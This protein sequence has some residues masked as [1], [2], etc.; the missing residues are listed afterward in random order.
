MIEDANGKLIHF[1]LLGY[2]DYTNYKD[3]RIR[4]RYLQSVSK[5]IGNWKTNNI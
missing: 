3:D 5:I 4:P 2:E 1:D